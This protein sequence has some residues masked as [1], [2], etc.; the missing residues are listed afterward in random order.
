M[1]DSIGRHRPPEFRF[2]FRN[3]DNK[4]AGSSNIYLSENHTLSSVHFDRANRDCVSL[5][6]EIRIQ[7]RHLGN[8]RTAELE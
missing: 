1:R 3:I 8:K 4:K 7:F 5:F 6:N 2:Q